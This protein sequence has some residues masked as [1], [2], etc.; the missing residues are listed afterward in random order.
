MESG[1]LR[2]FFFFNS[3]ILNLAVPI[4]IGDQ[5]SLDNYEMSTGI[6]LFGLFRAAPTAYESSQARGQTGAVSA[7]HTTAHGNAR[8][9][10]PCSRLGIEPASS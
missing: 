2:I 7:T 10:T 9:L 8:S 6:S 1:D 3:R 4:L 5:F